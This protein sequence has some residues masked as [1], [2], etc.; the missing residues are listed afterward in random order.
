MM[1]K[2]K[3][4]SIKKVDLNSLNITIFRIHFFSTPLFSF[5]QIDAM[6]GNRDSLT[7]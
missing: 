3:T 2:G 6:P 4:P 5:P 7:N 1:Q